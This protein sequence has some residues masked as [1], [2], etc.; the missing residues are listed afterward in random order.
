MD[1]PETPEL[2]VHRIGR[3]GRADRR[4]K[5]ITFVADYEVDKWNEIQTALSQSCVELKT[6]ARLVF[7]DVL[8]PQEV[9]TVAMPNMTVKNPVKLES[10]GAF[11]EKKEKNLKVNMHLTR[12]EKM[13]LKYG[14]PKKRRNN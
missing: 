5:S 2:Y 11:H 14:K 4:G 7:S 10:Q 9:P 13:R 6:P 8:L 12:A 1:V 3:T